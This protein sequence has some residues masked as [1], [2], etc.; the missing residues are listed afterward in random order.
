MRIINQGVAA[1]ALLFA[2]IF[3]SQAV[4]GLQLSIQCTNV[5]LKWPSVDGGGATYMIRYRPDLSANSSWIILTNYYPAATGTNITTFTN[6]GVISNVC[7]NCGSGGM[8]PMMAMGGRSIAN[9]GAA[10]TTTVSSNPPPLP[11]LP[12]GLAYSTNAGG[13]IIVISVPITEATSVGVVDNHG[14]TPLSPSPFGGTNSP[15]NSPPQTGFYEVVPDGATLYGL[16][17]NITIS[18]NLQLPVEVAN[19]VGQLMTLTLE[20]SGVPISTSIHIAPF[21]TPVPLMTLDTT[22]FSNGVHNISVHA[23]WSV[24]GGDEDGSAAVYEAYSDTNIITVY[25]EISFPNWMPEFGE[26]GNSMAICA[27]SAHTNAQWYIDIYDSQFAYIGTFEGVT[28]DG[29]INVV[30]NLLGPRGEYHADNT[31]EFVVTTIHDDPTTNSTVT[32]PAYRTT[33]PWNGPGD[34]VVVNQQAWDTVTGHEQLDI[35]TDGF[36]SAAQAGGLAVRPPP[37]GDGGAYRIRYGVNNPNAVSDW[38]AFRSALYNNLSRNLFYMGPGTPNE[39]GNSSNTNKTLTSK[40]VGTVLANIPAGLTNKHK[41]R[42]VF[43]DGCS[44]APGKF[45]E[46]FGIIHKEN[47]TGDYYYNASLRPSA[48]CGWNDDKVIAVANSVNTSHPNYVLHFMYQWS[49][50]IGVKQALINAKDLPDDTN[51]NTDKLIVFG[52]WNLTYFG[53]NR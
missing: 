20:D 37:N 17:N 3:Q 18:G 39:L 38:A 25:N 11:P 23:Q 29:I 44:T 36:V 32:P 51:I 8:S 52:S 41:F 2:S 9:T 31:F 47:V 28:P 24:A 4:P 22:Q 13:S 48:F 45:P 19:S 21:E 6:F 5:V 50:G 7:C 10:M 1:V 49:Q 35:M 12:P 43:L 30:W 26:L 46:A 14:G 16:T 40:E 15:N 27:V 53:F 42:Y 33:D 34:W